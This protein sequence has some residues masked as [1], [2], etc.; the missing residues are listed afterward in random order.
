M[1]STCHFNN[2]RPLDA[3]KGFALAVALKKQKSHRIF[4][5]RQ[6]YKDKLGSILYFSY[7]LMYLKEFVSMVFFLIFS[8][9]LS[10]NSYHKAM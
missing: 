3:L 1:R 6:K 9:A 2:Y 10:E 7:T 8:L 4:C 5:P